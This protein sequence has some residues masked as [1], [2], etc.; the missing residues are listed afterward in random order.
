MSAAPV[1]KPTVHTDFVSYLPN[2]PKKAKLYSL[3][4]PP[5][6]N[7][8]VKY[9]RCG[10]LHCDLTIHIICYCA[11]R[12]MAMVGL[13][14]ARVKMAIKRMKMCTSRV[15][16]AN[17]SYLSIFEPTRF[18]LSKIKSKTCSF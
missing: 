4:P 6:N 15:F 17:K 1:Q 12:L 18:I 9:K 3:G 10:L 16:C 5:A 8:K 2:P 7:Y 13:S 14:T 11:F